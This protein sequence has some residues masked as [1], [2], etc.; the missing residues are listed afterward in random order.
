MTIKGRYSITMNI[1]M[2]AQKGTLILEPEGSSLS[3]SIKS[4]LGSNSFAGGSIEGNEFSFTFKANAPML[5][6]QTFNVKG[7]VEGDTIS[8]NM[9]LAMGSFPFNGQRDE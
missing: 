9:S 4:I 2:G 8:G 5:G 6:E 3:G 1:S 7:S